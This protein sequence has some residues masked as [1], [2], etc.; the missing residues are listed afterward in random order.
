MSR[1]LA[2]LTVLA[3]LTGLLAVPPASAQVQLDDVGLLWNH[4]GGGGLLAAGSASGGVEQDNLRGWTG[5]GQRIGGVS[6]DGSILLSERRVIAL[7]DTGYRDLP[8]AGGR[9]VAF[10]SPRADRVVVGHRDRLSTYDLE[11][12][13]T[14]GNSGFGGPNPTETV[15]AETANEVRLAWVAP[16][17]GQMLYVD[18]TDLRAITL[19]NGVARTVADL[20]AFGPYPNVQLSWAPSSDR[21]AFAVASA[22]RSA[23]VAQVRTG[24]H[25]VVSDLA[26]PERVVTDIAHNPSGTVLWLEWIQP[27]G[28]QNFVVAGVADSDGSAIRRLG[29][30]SPFGPGVGPAGAVWLDDDTLLV[31]DIATDV[32]D[33]WDIDA[34]APHGSIGAMPEGYFPVRRLPVRSA[35]NLPP[36]PPPTFSQQRLDV[37]APIDGAVGLSVARF[38]DG[39]AAH[40]V[41]ARHDLFADSL[42]GAALTADGPL[43]YTTR[44]ALVPT[45]AQELQRALP[46]GAT[47]YVL[48]GENA[49]SDAVVAGVEALGLRVERLSGPSR[50]DTAVAVARAVLDRTPGEELYVARAGS[51]ASNPTAAW[52]DSVA[53]G[54]AAAATGIP[55]VVVGETLPQAVADLIVDEGITRATVLGGRA[56]VPDAVLDDLPSPRRLAGDTRVATAVA[57]ARDVFGFG[58]R[59]DGEMVLVNGFQRDGWAFGFAA[60]GFAAE[61]DVPV[62]LTDVDHL[63]QEVVDALVNC[64]G[65]PLPH[66]IGG[67]SLLGRF[68]LSDHIQA[69]DAS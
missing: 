44:D 14:I 30:R 63:P 11:E 7:D 34:N 32:L 48:G 56:A 46:D 31:P 53:G 8:V 26:T 28:G 5:N 24:D 38:D 3:V 35:A 64:D 51:P 55:V 17:G 10:G 9:L 33:L 68:I 18:G 39:D 37:E 27:E 43:L 22:D 69:C 6:P 13:I 49:L 36:G 67:M 20:S 57:I 2:V 66:L 58:E 59:G 25:A 1:H 29:E 19:P 41:L 23:S 61:L 16:D 60:A 52:A 40:A 47:V 50:V 15:L 45:T 4:A 65:G 21:Y 12:M 42:A 54:A 62:V